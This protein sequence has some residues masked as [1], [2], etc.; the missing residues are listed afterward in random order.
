MYCHE[1]AS[2]AK[3]GEEHFRERTQLMRW[4]LPVWLGHSEEELG[5][6]EG[7]EAGRGLRELLGKNWKEDKFKGKKKSS[8]L[9]LLYL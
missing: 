7:K 6:Y 2:H 1:G 8:V 9:A 5:W 3:K 4:P